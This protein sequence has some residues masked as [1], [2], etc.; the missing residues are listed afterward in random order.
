M[1]RVTIRMVK[2]ARAKIDNGV[3]VSGAARSLGLAPT[4]LR[5]HFLTEHARKRHI[6]RTIARRAGLS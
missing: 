1:S 5:Y 3:T 6:Q 4:T 2:E